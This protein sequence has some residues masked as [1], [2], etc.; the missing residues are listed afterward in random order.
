MIL[1]LVLVLAVI[2]VVVFNATGEPS[3]NNGTVNLEEVAATNTTDEVEVVSGPTVL[4][5]ELQEMFDQLAPTEPVRDENYYP[6]P[7]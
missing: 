4:D 6:T 1:L 2:G 5:E 3:E 7:E